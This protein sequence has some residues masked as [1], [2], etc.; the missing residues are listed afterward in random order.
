[1]DANIWLTL[2]MWCIYVPFYIIHHVI[3]EF[4]AISYI[5]SI[6][7]VISRSSS[8]LEAANFR[9][10]SMTDTEEL[11]YDWL[12]HY[13]VTWAS[14]RHISAAYRLFVQQLTAEMPS[15]LRIPGPVRGGYSGDRWFP[16]QRASNAEKVSMSWRHHARTVEKYVLCD[17]K[18]NNAP[19]LVHSDIISSFYTQHVRQ[20][21]LFVCRGLFVR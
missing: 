20:T 19:L 3:Y 12:H 5:F 11:V 2:L 21:F 10:D 6:L 14:W 18:T 4:T 15:K 16:S 17:S 1:M 13:D 8:K 9:S 7:L